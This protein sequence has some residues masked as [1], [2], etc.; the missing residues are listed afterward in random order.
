VRHVDFDIVVLVLAG[1][2]TA[3][4]GGLMFSFAVANNTGLRLV[5]DRTYVTAVQKINRGIVNPVFLPVFL[6]PVLLLPL[7]T[8]LAAGAEAFGWLLA[9]SIAYI[10]GPFGVTVTQN[11]PLNNRLDSV[12]VAAASDEDLATARGWSEGPWIRRHIVRTT[13]AIVAVVLVFIAVTQI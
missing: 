11:I 3:L 10:V 8:I 9:A 12:D 7:A 4:M 2:L 1:T 5:D 6:G 13:L